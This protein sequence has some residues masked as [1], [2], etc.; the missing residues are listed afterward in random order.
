MSNYKEIRRLSA[1]DLRAL[2]ITQNWYTRGTQQEYSHLLYDLAAHKSHLTTQDIIE[3]AQDILTHSELPDGYDAGAIAWEVN[4]V[5][6]VCFIQE[7]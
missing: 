4:R 1:Y 5:C 7:Q 3:I 2:C 6:N